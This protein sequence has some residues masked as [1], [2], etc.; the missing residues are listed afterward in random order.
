MIKIWHVFDFSDLSRHVLWPVLGVR[1]NGKYQEKTCLSLHKFWLYIKQKTLF[2]SMWD[3]STTSPTGL[4]K[5]EGVD[6]FLW[7]KWPHT[8][9]DPVKRASLDAVEN[10]SKETHGTIH[11]CKTHCS[12]RSLHC[13]VSPRVSK[14]KSDSSSPWRA[15]FDGKDF[16][17][18]CIYSTAVPA[19]R[20]ELCVL[21]VALC[22]RR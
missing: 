22:T 14:R 10:L 20:P 11:T 7:L 19:D 4:K 21:L 15:C 8:S 12:L 2:L 1:T 18:C 16:R 17:F 6:I 3:F 13:W 9:L 5:K